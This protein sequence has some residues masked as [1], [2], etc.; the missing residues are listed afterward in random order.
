MSGSYSS[1][2]STLISR[3]WFSRMQ[4]I[5]N[6]QVH[7]NVPSIPLTPNTSMRLEVRR[8]GTRYSSVPSRST[9]LRDF[10]NGPLL[11]DAVEIDVGHGPIALHQNVV[12]VPIAQSDHLPLRTLSPFLKDM[13]PVMLHTAVVCVNRS[14]ACSH[15]RGSGKSRRSHS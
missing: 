5:A 4:R 12:L 2:S 9:H 6:S 13:Y 15:C 3:S 11:E 14:R 7:R 8:N 10:Q 1:D